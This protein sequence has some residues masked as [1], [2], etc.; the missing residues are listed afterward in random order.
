MK[1]IT[2]VKNEYIIRLQKLLNKK[3][4]LKE[5][6]FLVEGLHLVEEAKLHLV[7]V[8]SNDEKLLKKYSCDTYL[9]TDEIIKK[10]STTVNPQPIIGVVK[11]LNHNIEILNKIFKSQKARI[12]ILDNLNDPGNLGT[13]IRTS[14]GLGMDAIIMSH[15]TVD[16]YNDKVL[17]STQGSIFKLPIVKTDILS[18]I[19]LLKQNQFKCYGTSLQK[20]YSI[21]EIN[22]SNKY[23]IVVGNEANGVRDEVL[24]LMDYNIKLPMKHDVESFNV[25]IASAIIM[26]EFLREDIFKK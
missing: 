17:R 8:L 7:S 15:D 21:G 13:I 24:S 20:A 2:S 4:R 12:L 25:G 5:Q 22:K 19:K 23:A 1:T 10:L 3:D 16:I 14:A 9:V 6:L 18:V 26:Y 11:M